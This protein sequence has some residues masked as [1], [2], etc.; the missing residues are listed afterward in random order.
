MSEKPQVLLVDTSTISRLI[1]VGGEAELDLLFRS[2]RQVVITNTVHKEIVKGLG[3]GTST[4]IAYENWFNSNQDKI[5]H[6]TDIDLPLGPKNVGEQSLDAFAAKYGD[7]YDIRALAD[8]KGFIN[9]FLNDSEKN[10]LDKGYSGKAYAG[11]G[12]FLTEQMKPEN[13]S[14]ISPEEVER[15]RT[16]LSE[17]VDNNKHAASLLEFFPE[18]EKLQAVIDNPTNSTNWDAL[19]TKSVLLAFAADTFNK[20]GLA[21][22]IVEYMVTSAQAAEFEQAGDFEAAGKLWT[23]YMFGLG[24]GSALAPVGAAGGVFIGGG[25][26]SPTGWVLGAIGGI[27]LGILG[28]YGGK[29]LGAYLYDKNP[30][31]FDQLFLRGGKLDENFIDGW[32][33]TEARGWFDDVSIKDGISIYPSEEKILELDQIR[34]ARIEHNQLIDAKLELYQAIGSFDFNIQTNVDLSGEVSDSIGIDWMTI[35]NQFISFDP[36]KLAAVNWRQEIDWDN[37]DGFTAFEVNDVLTTADVTEVMEAAGLTYV[38]DDPPVV[39]IIPN[40]EG[41]PSLFMLRDSEGN[42]VIDNL[43][44]NDGSVVEA[45]ISGAI[46]FQTLTQ[47]SDGTSHSETVYYN[48]EKNIFVSNTINVDSGET[49]T[50]VAVIS[51]GFNVV[52]F[53]FPNGV[54]SLNTITDFSQLYAHGSLD[55][56]KAWASIDGLFFN[57]EPQENGD[58][59]WSRIDTFQAYNLRD[60]INALTIGVNPTPGT[61]IVPDNYGIPSLF[62]HQDQNGDYQ[63]YDSPLSTTPVIPNIVQGTVVENFDY[64]KPIAFQTPITSDNATAYENIS[65]DFDNLTIVKSV[66]L[67]NELTSVQFIEGDSDSLHSVPGVVVNY[68]TDAQSELLGKSVFDSLK[69][70]GVSDADHKLISYGGGGSGGHPFNAVKQGAT[71]THAD[72][73]ETSLVDYAQQVSDGTNVLIN[74]VGE[75]LSK[76]P[77]YL[78][79]LAPGIISDL[80]RGDDIEEVAER[81]AIQLGVTIGVDV[82]LDTFGDLAAGTTDPNAPN[83]FDSGAGAFLKGAIIQFAVVAALRGEDMEGSDY[84]KLIANYSIRSALTEVVKSTSWGSAQVPLQQSNI[85]SDIF[86][87]NLTSGTTSTGPTTTGL[88]PAGAGAVAAAVTF[89]ANLIDHGFEDFEQTLVQT[90]VAGATSYIGAALAVTLGPLG[91]VIGAVLGN[92]LGSLFGPGLPPPPPLFRIEENADGSQTVYITAVSGGY[93]YEARDGFNDVLVGNHGQDNLIGS[94]GD[95]ELFGN[96]NNDVLNGHAGDDVLSGGDGDDIAV[97]GLGSDTVLGGAG[98]DNLFGDQSVVKGE[99]NSAVNNTAEGQDDQLIAG[100]GDD[101]A[102]GGA[103]NDYISGGNGNDVLFGGAGND[104]VSGDEGDDQINGGI[105]DDT[106]YGDTLDANDETQIIETVGS[107]NDTIDAGAGDD[108]VYGG[109]GDDNILGGLGADRIYGDGIRVNQVDPDNVISALIGSGDDHIDG[110]EGNDIIYGGSGADIIIGGAGDDF[111]EG[112][113][114]NDHLTGGSGD[115]ILSGNE[116]NDSLYGGDG[117]D[118]LTGNDGVDELFGGAGTDSLDGGLGNDSLDGGADN[119]L[120][121]GDLGDD[122]ILGGEGDDLAFGGIGNDI[123]DGGA[124]DDTILGEIGDDTL[125]GG[126]GDDTLSGGSQNDTLDG[127]LG[128]DLLQGGSGDDHLITLAG[129]DRLEGGSENDTY[130]VALSADETT[131]FDVSGADMLELYGDIKAKDIILSVDGDDLIVGLRS[132]DTKTIRVLGQFDADSHIMLEAIKFSDGFTINISQM[133]IG[134]EGDNNLTGTDMDDGILGL[135]GDDNILGQGGDDFLDGGA[136]ED[137]IY[138]GAGNDQIHGSSE[139]DLLSGDQGD[140]TIIDGDGNDL[141]IGGQGNDTFVIGNSG[142]ADQDT[143]ADFVKGEDRIDL[144]GFGRQFV[145]RKQLDYFGSRINQTVLMTSLALGTAQLLK[146][147]GLGA[148]TLEDSDFIFDQR[149]AEGTNGSDQNDII[150]GTNADEIIFDG[151]GF[152]V[153]TGGLGK[154]QFTISAQQGDIDTITD[155]TIDEDKI[156]LARVTQFISANHLQLEQRNNDVIIHLPNDQYVIVENTNINQLTDDQFDFD[157]F[158]NQTNVDRFT[159]D[160]TYD[161]TQDEVVEDNSAELTDGVYSLEDFAAGLATNWDAQ[162]VATSAPDASVI[163]SNALGDAQGTG[164]FSTSANIDSEGVRRT[165]TNNEYWVKFGKWYH[166]NER[167][168]LTRDYNFHASNVYEE[169]ISTGQILQVLPSSLVHS[170]IW[171]EDV[172]EDDEPDYEYRVDGWSY[173]DTVLGEEDDYGHPEVEGVRFAIPQGE[174]TYFRVVSRGYDPD[175]EDHYLYTKYYQVRDNH[176][177]DL[178]H[179]GYWGEN[180][181]G[182]NGHDR[183]YGNNG[184]DLIYGGTGNDDLYGGD[185]NDTLFGQ[186]GNDRLQADDGND[187]LDGGS[188]N[189]VLL[190]GIG[191]NT[192]N[193][194]TENDYLAGYA[195]DDTASGGAGDDYIL[196][197]D[198]DD[199]LRGDEGKDIIYGE[200]GDDVLEGGDRDDYLSGGAGA[201]QLRGDDG[202]DILIGGDGDDYLEGGQGNDRLYAGTG[203]NQL[204]GD[205]GDDYLQAGDGDNRFFGGAGN[206]KIVLGSGDDYAEGGSGNDLITAT[207]GQNWIHGGAGIDAIYG[208]NLHDT[209][210]G[211]SGSDFIDGGDGSDLIKGGTNDDL[212]LGGE[213]HDHI[214]GG[215]G[216]DLL[217]GDAGSDLIIGGAGADRLEGGGGNDFLRGDDLNAD[218]LNAITSNDILLGGDGNDT[219]EGGIGNDILTGGAGS[220]TFVFNSSWGEDTITDFETDGGSRDLI[221]FSRRSDVQAFS[222]LVISY[223]DGYALVSSEFGQIRLEGVTAGLSEVDF[224]FGQS[225]SNIAPV[226]KLDQIVSG[227]EDQIVVI[228]PTVLL[229]NDSDVDGD[230]FSLHGVG[231]AVHGSVEINDDGNI[232]FTPEANYAGLASFDYTIIDSLGATSTNSVSISLAGTEDAVSLLSALENQT[233][234]EDASWSFI[235]PENTFLDVDGDVLSYSVSLADDSPLPSWLSFN[236]STRELSGTPPQDFNGSV[237]FKVRAVDSA[238]EAVDEFT[239]TVLPVNDAPIALGDDSFVTDEDNAIIIAA[240]DLLNNDSDVEGDILSLISVSDATNGTVVI[241]QGGDVSFTPA[242]NYFGNAS[243]RYTVSDGNGGA[244]SATVTLAVNAVNDAVIIGQPIADQQIEEDGVWTYTLPIDSFIDVDGDITYSARLS[245]DMPLPDWISFDADTQSFS[246]TPPQDFNGAYSIKVSATDGVSEISDVFSFTITPVNDAPDAVADSEYSTDID[247]PLLISSSELLANDTDVDGD[248][249]TIMS[250]QSAVNGSVE[251]DDNGDVVF[252]P[253]EGFSGEAS[254]IYTLSDSQGAK[255]TQLVSINIIDTNLAGQFAEFEDKTQILRYSDTVSYDFTSDST[256]ENN[257]SELPSGLVGLDDFVQSQISNWQSADNHS[258]A[259]AHDD[260]NGAGYYTASSNIDTNGVGRSATNGGNSSSFNGGGNTIHVNGWPI[261]NYLPHHIA[262]AG[263]KRGRYDEDEEGFVYSWSSPYWST[264]SIS[265]GRNFIVHDYYT[266]GGITY[267]RTVREIVEDDEHTHLERSYRFTNYNVN[268][269]MHGGA[270]NETISGNKGHDRIYANNGHDTLHGNDGNDDL[271][272]GNG[273]DTVFGDSGNDRLHG[274]AGGD[275][276]DGGSGN[277]VIFGGDGNDQLIGG[278]GKDYLSGDAG[279]DTLY[280]G[281]DADYLLGGVGNDILHGEAGN[282]HLDGGE[283]DDIILGHAG[284]DNIITGAGDDYVEGGSGNDVITASSGNNWLHGGTGIDAIYGGNSHDIIFGGSGSDFIDGGSGND[285]I[286]GGT[287]DDLISGGTGHDDISGDQGNDIINGND[288][289]DIINGGEGNDQIDGGLGN[290]MLTG[291]LGLDS[292][293]FTMNWGH[294]TITDFQLDSDLIDFSNH[295]G[296]TQLDDLTIIYSD[297]NGYISDGNNI[298]KVENLDRT[299]EVEDFKFV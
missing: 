122:T 145:T 261:T 164:Y 49:N 184:D 149:V 272:G 136:G 238:S 161:F 31:L 291:G 177:N 59:D 201:D 83:F 150:T 243:F 165:E 222:D 113:D 15:V 276:L 138:G 46:N 4:R 97:G 229:S 195:G 139:D 188:G 115:D 237:E 198:G 87:G 162:S 114:G 273:N 120:L 119:D 6:A 73:T 252:T 79:T 95:N 40:E 267:Y 51:D 275:Y 263:A 285:L 71:V 24:A 127:G 7:Q 236:E 231:N 232:I 193:G 186:S 163:S 14:A 35:G 241:N 65:I 137:I 128:N 42:L 180:I 103:G 289:D 86:N 11:L 41:L 223:H 19:F 98:S 210:F 282:D 5:L 183:I 72:G 90:A 230:T 89:F 84:A 125:F 68:N 141:L 77:L 221:D 253:D 143:I 30:E 208:G 118:Q 132:D 104:T 233:I 52:D 10:I 109:N 234:A 131:I 135:G 43:P 55:D 3:E 53:E 194:G 29:Q 117:N 157:V 205:D 262:Y 81:Y 239:L 199:V 159:G 292:F 235:I 88:S 123:L 18:Q 130:T 266:Y 277:D 190:G 61:I 297:G 151:K 213:G 60:E 296:I 62:L 129:S 216:N 179:G 99:E 153:L 226:A 211:G 255:D 144:T 34:L 20:L 155:F 156:D 220:D 170:R 9:S 294:D 174:K 214:E 110:G 225:I 215:Q 203:N 269:L 160:V 189:D 212:I 283:G 268:D 200:A 181:Q 298:L 242:A 142:N 33:Y 57:Y 121:R 219:L 39:T 191:N 102:F 264:Q 107:G 280:G 12:D 1:D 224:R 45:E 94:D 48:P 106:I 178:L 124:G 259:Y 244:S 140:D 54:G 158:K 169:Q 299:F 147:E 167:W 207:S 111:I 281:T 171:R 21:G 250:V 74:N 28:E 133:I 91:Y 258:S 172:G 185:G 288:G 176:P 23:E 206:D 182:N 286:S 175:E 66:P 287:N 228:D 70:S 80:I 64:S 8:E 248:S 47:H 38:Q 76:I 100:D 134:D 16:G 25:P 152:D 2:N 85:L 67:T 108:T 154:D 101:Y 96:G 295:S 13:G 78:N 209:I 22:D 50:K 168:E 63:F 271:Y 254:F 246:G 58:I 278:S 36:E 192:L 284:D 257:V 75:E 148:S 105:G 202:A 173:F 116:G 270:W 82:L 166:G 17:L 187:V 204:H 146:I 240:T 56:G 251:F 92:L 37:L 32:A 279:N 126:A 293:I 196:G 265:W 26:E 227:T 249:L 27:G 218:P 197:G 217:K 274:D 260:V 44:S 247:A 69:T 93:V 112:N 245:D 256:I 290:D